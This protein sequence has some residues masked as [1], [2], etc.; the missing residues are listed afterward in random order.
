MIG[1]GSTG[2][3]VGLFYSESKRNWGYGFFALG[4]VL[5]AVSY[6]AFQFNEASLGWGSAGASGLS[7]VVGGVLILNSRKHSQFWSRN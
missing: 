6:G 5:A 1:S 4:A 3:E 7:F 2:R